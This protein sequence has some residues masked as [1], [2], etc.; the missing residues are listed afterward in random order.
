MESIAEK[1]RSGKPPTELQKQIGGI[2]EALA[3]LTEPGQVVELRIP[4]AQR[5]GNR[6]DAGYFDNAQDLAKMAAAQGRGGSAGVYV[7]LNPVNPALLARSANRIEQ[8]AKN[9]TQDPDILY[10]RWLP[11]DADPVRPSGISSTEEEHTAALERAAKIRAW[12]TAKG[13]PSPLPADSG[14]G[15]H[16]LYRL[17]D[18]PNTAENTTLIQRCTEAL[19]MAWDD[20]TV[21]IDKTVFNASRIWK[22]YGTL[23]AKGDHTEDRPHR[24]ARILET[25]DT[26]D[27]VTEEQLQAL[28]ATLPEPVATPTT[29]RNGYR[30]TA[31]P[32]DLEEWIR[33]HSLDVGTPRD[34]NS[35]QGKAKKWIFNVCPW[36]SAHTDKSAYLMQF[37]NGA[38]SA[39][40]HHSG[41]S[42]QD[43]HSLREKFDGPKEERSRGQS[44]QTYRNGTGP[45][46]EEKTPAALGLALD[47]MIELIQTTAQD[48]AL[49]QIDKQRAIR[50]GLALAIDETNRATHRE[51][52]TALVEAG[53][54]TKTEAQTFI[55]DCVADARHRR[56][57]QKKA[58][59]QA[60]AD[61]QEAKVASSPLPTIDVTDKQLSE[62]EE[63]AI[64]AIVT[65][66]SLDPARPVLYVRGGILTRV[67]A[68]ENGNHSTQTVT[69]SAC[70]ATIAKCADWIRISTDNEGIERITNTFPPSDVARAVVNR[71][72]WEEIP[73]LEGIVNVP[74]FG[75][76][77]KLHATPGYNPHT[78]LYYT[79]GVTLS[80][81]TP[82]TAHIDTARRLLLDDLFVD[83]P[84]RD[85]ASLAHAVALFLLPYVRPMI[86]GAT[87]LHLIDA[88]T[89]GTGKGLLGD[90]CAIPALGRELPSTTAGKDD[91]EWR[92]R[93]T[94]A[95]LEG[96]N[97]VSIDNITQPLDSGVLASVLTQ[98]YWQD[99]ILG[100]SL[101]VN[102]RVRTIWIANGNNVVPSDEIARRA[103]W[104]RIDANQEKPWDRKEFKHPR[105]KTW[106]RENRDKLVTAAITLIRAWVDRDMPEYTGQSKGSYDTWA[107]I[108]GGILKTVGIP[109][110]LGNE[111]ELFATTVN[112]N[113]VLSEFVKAWKDTYGQKTVSVSGDLFPLASYPDKT[114]GDQ[115]E[116][117]NL[118]EE[119]LGAGNEASRKAR[120]GKLLERNRDKVIAGAKIVK[121]TR[122]SAGMRYRLEDVSAPQ[123]SGLAQGKREWAL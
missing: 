67:V 112:E 52:V 25:P 47:A 81:T 6:T 87:P 1:Q 90:I 96:G 88:P 55:R 48:T 4:N 7:T 60:R 85:D 37:P 73:A 24:W 82:T 63:E 30:G 39:G 78:R 62:L 108:L 46:T 42:G 54:Y 3:L 89:P 35:T 92:K 28:A 49:E 23:A 71:G 51:I 15:A 38:I 95:L 61:A 58:K 115:S 106:A 77:G 122:S 31:T 74:V 75:P 68:D 114:E 12:L 100:A 65:T 19:A 36:N 26:I 10:R 72:E 93:I 116:Y 103:V 94:S 56:T 66:N 117:K 16:L 84:F 102:L 76:D 21:T 113:S 83:F 99:R 43:W 80:D 120:L 22:L 11:L 79:G 53:I 109:G 45:H 14:N 69:E 57:E 18:L 121:E 111:N 101:T 118:L 44:P 29:N 86:A 64:G 27:P 107:N 20:D 105:L 17:P 34:W 104:I 50:E 110:F 59:R 9:L 97:F 33:A 13:W 8:Y 123:Q 2:V 40:C 41:C 32:L 5:R 91:D 70:K 98:S 119:L